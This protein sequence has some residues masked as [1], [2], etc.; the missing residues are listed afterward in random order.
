[1]TF[2]E[3]SDKVLAYRWC[4]SQYV[5]SD[6]SELTEIAYDLEVELY[7]LT[8]WERAFRI[9]GYWKCCLE[10]RSEATRREQLTPR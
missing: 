7:G 4:L 10:P 9:V 8:P 1:M 3:S 2:D 6:P 5:G